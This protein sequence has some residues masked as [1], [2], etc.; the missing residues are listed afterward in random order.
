MKKTTNKN[1]SQSWRIASWSQIDFP[2]LQTL[3][4]QRY[5]PSVICHT[6]APLILLHL[7]EH[8]KKAG[9]STF[10]I[11]LSVLSS[12]LAEIDERMSPILP[13]FQ[14]PNCFVPHLK[15]DSF[16]L[17][18]SSKHSIKQTL[19]VPSLIVERLNLSQEPLWSQ[20]FLSRADRNLRQ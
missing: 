9:Q 10:V 17:L 4:T 19:C 20:R 16:F 6:S 1:K 7:I 13:L 11:R 5:C 18:P 15:N 2:E 12:I 14:T 3:S 8:F